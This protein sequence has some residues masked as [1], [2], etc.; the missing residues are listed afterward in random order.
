MPASCVGAVVCLCGSWSTIAFIIGGLLIG[1]LADRPPWNRRM[2]KLLL[3]L[4]VVTSLI[5]SFF[6]FAL[7]T[8][9]GGPFIHN[10]G[11]DAIR[12][13]IVLASGTLGA[14]CPL[15]YESC[16]EITFPEPEV[17]SSNVIIA[18]LNSASFVFLFIVAPLLKEKVLNLVF[19][20]CAVLA[21][22]G[23]AA[24]N[25]S[26]RRSAAEASESSGSGGGGRPGFQ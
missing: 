26:Y 23:F 24:C 19:L 7:P 9:L 17:Y 22:L 21:V 25:I 16:A 8:A 15:F 4:A 6:T 14:M 11:L 12:V 1:L 18:V 5:S 10:M 20:G 3:G 2:K 13:G